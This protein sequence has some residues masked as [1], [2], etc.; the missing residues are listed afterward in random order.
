MSKDNKQASL[1]DTSPMY[2]G[3][4]AEIVRT[5]EDF[6]ERAKAGETIRAAF[7]VQHA[8]GT[9]EDIIFAPTKEEEDQLRQE[10]YQNL[11]NA[12]N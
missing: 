5:L 7:R 2:V 6:L 10:L 9:Y 12:A 4:Q 8:D 1:T 3:T 11:R